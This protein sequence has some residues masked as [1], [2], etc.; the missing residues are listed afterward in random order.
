MIYKLTIGDGEEFRVDDLT[1]GINA[2]GAV[3]G[4]AD[5]FISVSDREEDIFKEASKKVWLEWLDACC[6][7]KHN[8]EER[9]RRVVAK[10]YAGDENTDVVR[11]IKIE[12]AYLASYVESS[13]GT[14]HY[15]KAEIRRAPERNA[16]VT[17]TAS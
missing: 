9:I 12:K 6:G 15:Y 13:E 8:P 2:D 11:N 3:E 4:F 5:I 17:V 7:D 1:Y 14:N 16:E 10:I